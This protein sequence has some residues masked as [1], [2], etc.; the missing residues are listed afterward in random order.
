MTSNKRITDLTDYVSIL[1]YA[2]ELFG[3]YQPL[4]GWRSKR[5]EVRFKSGFA[6]DAVTRTM[7]LRRFYRGEA[8]VPFNADAQME[9][10]RVAVARPGP[11]PPRSLDGS[12]LMAAL[13]K[14]LAGLDPNREPEWRDLINRDSLTGLLNGEV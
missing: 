9:A 10:G 3:I 5:K 11:P 8:E 14:Q 1:P 4:I 13:T 7:A 6:T 2:S 12:R